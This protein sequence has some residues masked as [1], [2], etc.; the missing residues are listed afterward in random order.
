MYPG[1]T[2]T[3][4]LGDLLA[5]QIGVTSEPHVKIHDITQADRFITIATDGVWRYLQADDVN[6]IVS[7]FGMKDPGQSCELIGQKIKDI[8]QQDRQEMDDITMIISQL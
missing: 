8:C 4:S 5:H 2:I 1:L 3:R 6:E 7:E